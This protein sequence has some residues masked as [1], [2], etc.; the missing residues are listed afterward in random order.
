MLYKWQQDVLPI[1]TNIC[2]MLRFALASNP[3]KLFSTL[4]YYL[5]YSIIYYIEQDKGCFA[6]RMYN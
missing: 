6:K 1:Y 5:I 3:D 2:V 4:L